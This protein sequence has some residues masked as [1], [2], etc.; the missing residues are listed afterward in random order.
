MTQEKTA[1][2]YQA[3]V[4]RLQKTVQN[5]ASSKADDAIFIAELKAVVDEQQQII[6]YVQNQNKELVDENKSLK[7]YLEQTTAPSTVEEGEAD[8]VTTDQ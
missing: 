8:E 3:E 1:E 5:L 4:N 2:Q 7:S 6:D